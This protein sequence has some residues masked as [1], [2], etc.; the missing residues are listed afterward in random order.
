MTTELDLDGLSISVG[1]ITGLLGRNGSGKSRL[2]KAAFARHR[3]VSYLPQTDF[4]PA[5]LRLQRL[6]DDFQLTYSS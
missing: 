2:M 3:N 5:A 6:S 4:I 1:R